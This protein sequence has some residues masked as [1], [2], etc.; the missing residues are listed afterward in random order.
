MSNPESKLRALSLLA[1]ADEA[2]AYGLFYE[3]LEKEVTSMVKQARLDEWSS[4]EIKLAVQR[5][6]LAATQRYEKEFKQ[7]FVYRERN[8]LLGVGEDESG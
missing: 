1:K 8:R 4:D 6:H 5:A 2:F 3:E 7:S